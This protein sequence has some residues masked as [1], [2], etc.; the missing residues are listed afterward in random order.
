MQ[1]TLPDDPLLQKRA[2][3]A[4][5]V[6]IEEYVLNLLEQEA[7]FDEERGIAGEAMSPEEWSRDFRAFLASLPPSNP[8]FDDS[9]ESIYPVR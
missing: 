6:K 3:A 2:D 9:R 8:N 5:F 4:G 1:I 7:E